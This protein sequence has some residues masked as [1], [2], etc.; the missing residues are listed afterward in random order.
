MTD[1]PPPAGADRRPG[2]PARVRVTAVVVTRG[3]SE[4]LAE[5]LAGLAA[6]TVLPSRVVLVDVGD[7]ASVEA[8]RL[9]DGLFPDPT[10]R[11]VGRTSLVRALHAR[12]FGEAVRAGLASVHD[13]PDEPDEAA[14][15]WLW[16]LHDDAA[17]EPGTLAELLRAVEVA[18]SVAVAGPKQ[19]TWAGP[20]RIVEAGV[21][22]SRFGRRMTGIDEPEVDQGQHDRRED[23]LAVGLAGALVRRDVWDDLGGPDPA[24]GPYGDGLDLCRR[25]RL[26]GHRVVVVPGAVVRHARATLALPFGGAVL[27]RPGWDARRAARLQREAFLHAQLA[28]VPLG[29]VPVVAVLALVSGVLRGAARLVSKEPHLVLAE[30]AA[31]WGALLRP[32]RVVR[33]RRKAARTRRLP[34]RS[35]RPLQASWRDVVRQWRDRRLSR[36]EQRRRQQAPSELELRELAALRRRRRWTW[37][38]L[39]VVLVGVVVGAFGALLAPVL[40]GT[41]LRGGTLPE[42]ATDVAGLWASTWSGWLATGLGSPVPAEPTALALL[43]GAA[44]TGSTGAALSVLLLLSVVLAGLGAWAAAGAGTRSVAVRAWVGVVWAASPALLLATAGARWGAVLAHVLLPW[45]VLGTARGLG[46]ARRDVVE[47]GL[48]AED[49]PEGPDLAGRAGGDGPTTSPAR[50]VPPPGRT[51]PASLAA[52]AGGAL[53]LAVVVAGAPALLA[54]VVPAVAV[55]ALVT[56]RRRLLWVPVPAL[57]LQAPLLVD[58]LRDGSWRLLLTEPGRPVASAPTGWTAILGDVGGQV[59]AAALPALPLPGLPA[60]TGVALAVPVA[61]VALV[62]L[63]RGGAAV[64]PS[65]VGWSLAALGAATAAVSSRVVVAVDGEEPVTPWGGA[66]ASL[67]LAGLLVAAVAGADGTRAA[68][69]RH[70][71]GARQLVASVL[72]VVSVLAPLLGLAGWVVVARGELARP[73]AERALLDL[74]TADAPVVPAAGRQLQRP[75]TS[76]R[77][78]VVDVR[79]GDR[80][81]LRLLREDGSGPADLSRAV[82]ALTVTGAPGAPAVRPADDATTDLTAVVAE[83]VG[84]SGEDVAA[85]LARLGVGAVL[86]PPSAVGSEEV[87]ARGTVLAGLDSTAGLERV[88]ETASGILWRVAVDGVPA[89]WARVVGPAGEETP[90]SSQGLVAAGAVPAGAADRRVLLAERADVGWR[91]TLDGRPLRAVEDGWRQAFELGAEGGE[92]RV[93]HVAP[94]TTAWRVLQLAVLAVTALLAVPVGRRRGG[95]R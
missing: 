40:T 33:A 10:V 57:A 82:A 27:H 25:A 88:T 62:G 83:L 39:L 17:P 31:P 64:R 66:G 1:A 84:G 9:L 34:R 89:S 92:L 73:A 52:L 20:R 93:V 70:A 90:L 75:P 95:Q 16:L 58:A 86:V 2:V 77:V 29:L 67:A 22:T 28:G 36:A 26:A 14:D 74:R 61:V 47:P 38:G 50:T 15:G 21:T 30:L 60:W 80:V 5:T 3:D 51:A 54:A 76:A 79:A 43:P 48:P 81:D 37:A 72:V 44:L 59:P 19:H 85:R 56:P 13:K 94:G 6:Q 68:L 41:G 46:V 63:V 24:L 35:L 49:A 18:P 42:A 78:A 65:R 11:G 87:V 91:A 12:T 4:Y 69:A 7:P 71:F 23:V 55:L 45:V 53:V 32:D 8:P